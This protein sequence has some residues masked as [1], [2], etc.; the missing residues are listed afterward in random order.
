M[1]E[2]DGDYSS[3]MLKKAAIDKT[4]KGDQTIHFGCL[5]M[6]CGVFTF[7]TDW[8]FTVTYVL[9]LILIFVGVLAGEGQKER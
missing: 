1:M 6:C 3:P 7:F 5:Y 9:S 2:A 8:R 4:A